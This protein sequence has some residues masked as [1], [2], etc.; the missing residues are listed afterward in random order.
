MDAYEGARRQADSID[1]HGPKVPLADVEAS[2]DGTHGFACR[3][4][5]GGQQQHRLGNNVPAQG[6]A[7]MKG[8]RGGRQSSRQ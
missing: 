4:V 7:L 8:R 1:E 6:M 5:A 2:G 3:A